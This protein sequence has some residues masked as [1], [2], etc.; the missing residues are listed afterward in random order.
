VAWVW[1]LDAPCSGPRSCTQHPCS[2]PSVP[3][4]RR[5]QHRYADSVETQALQ[6]QARR[7]KLRIRAPLPEAK[8]WPGARGAAKLWRVWARCAPVWRECSGT[9]AEYPLKT[10]CFD[11]L[12]CTWCVPQTAGLCHIMSTHNVTWYVT[13]TPSITTL[14]CDIL[15]LVPCQGSVILWDHGRLAAHVIVQ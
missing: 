10:W 15:T 14:R 7:S 4:S 11:T 2:P 12:A 8:E 13:H 5:C 3:N 1:V 6:T 9:S